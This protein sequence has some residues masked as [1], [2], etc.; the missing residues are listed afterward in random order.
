[1]AQLRI[2]LFFSFA[3]KKLLKVSKLAK[4]EILWVSV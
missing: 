1:M 4:N 3:E 2:G